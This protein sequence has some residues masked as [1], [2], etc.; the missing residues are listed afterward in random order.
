MPMASTVHKPPETFA[1][2]MVREPILPRIA[3]AVGKSGDLK[4]IHAKVTKWKVRKILAY[5]Q[6]PPAFFE[7]PRQVCHRRTPASPTPCRPPHKTKFQLGPCHKPPR[8]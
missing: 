3:D 4:K 5:L 2:E 6:K 1:N 7:V 8:S